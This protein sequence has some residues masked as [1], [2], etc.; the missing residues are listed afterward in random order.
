MKIT[1]KA[2][3]PGPINPNYYSLSQYITASS[4]TI[5]PKPIDRNDVF[6]IRLKYYHKAKNRRAEMTIRPKNL[7]Q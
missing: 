4:W 1:I 7:L 5:G 3:P 2:N 6:T